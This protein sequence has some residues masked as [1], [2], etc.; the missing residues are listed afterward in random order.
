M[1]II[2]VLSN[3]ITSMRHFKC[4]TM[5]WAKRV[6]TG[7]TKNNVC[8]AHHR[9]H[10]FLHILHIDNVACWWQCSSNSSS[11]LW[12][13]PLVWWLLHHYLSGLFSRFLFAPQSMISIW[14][15]ICSYEYGDINKCVWLRI[16]NCKRSSIAKAC[17]M[18]RF[19]RGGKRRADGRAGGKSDR[20][21]IYREYRVWM[22]IKTWASTKCH[23]Y[24]A[25]FMFMKWTCDCIACVC[26]DG[27]N[28]NI[29]SLLAV[30]WA[31]ICV[32]FGMPRCVYVY[33]SN[34]VW[35]KPEQTTKFRQFSI[36]VRSTTSSIDF[37]PNKVFTLC[38]VFTP[39]HRA[40]K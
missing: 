27:T 21:H 30:L 7:K 12:C 40:C 8:K 24:I 17:A 38:T 29:I 37:I 28:S 20:A 5:R 33:I 19:L 31:Y 13:S 11:L 14:S 25:A 26:V 4:N 6:A 23:T 22:D 32:R 18:N 10:T 34:N 35:L 15:H 3:A 16:E 2:P 9:I 1:F 36:G 39:Q